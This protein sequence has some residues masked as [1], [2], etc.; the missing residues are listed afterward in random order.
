LE[1]E[2]TKWR[3]N[4]AFIVEIN[5]DSFTRP[6][7]ATNSEYSVHDPD[8]LAGTAGRLFLAWT[9]SVN[10]RNQAVLSRGWLR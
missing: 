7:Q 2:D 5:G 9:E 4:Q 10:D 8:M 1:H 6:I 3:S